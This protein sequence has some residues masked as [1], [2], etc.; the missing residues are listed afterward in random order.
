MKAVILAGGLGTRISEETYDKPKPMVEI[1]GLPILWH[2]IKYYSEW[3]FN[4]FIICLGYKGFII[5][6]FFSNYYLHSSNVTID[7]KNNDLIF[8]NSSAENWKVTLIETGKATQTGGRLKMVYDFIKDEEFFAFTYGDGLSNLNIAKQIDFHKN[9]GKAVTI[10]SV[11]P[12]GRYGALIT[13]NNRVN[14]FIEKPMGDGGR[15]NGGFFLLSPK[16]I[17]YI[18]DDLMPW[19][20]QPLENLAKKGEVFAFEHSEFWQAMDTLRDKN[21]LE[22]LWSKGIAPWKIWR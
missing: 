16:V 19:E 10:T 17:E 6:E 3:G 15:I 5:K 2:I 18:K 21:Y 22:D 13:Q 8:H 7:L 12:P 4:E 14:K 11:S 1:G 20:G 9:H